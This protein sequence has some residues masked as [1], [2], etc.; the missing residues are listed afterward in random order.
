MTYRTKL[1]SKNNKLCPSLCYEDFKTT[2]IPLNIFLN[3]TRTVIFTVLM[4]R[5]LNID[6]FPFYISSDDLGY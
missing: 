1:N 5:G 4:I 2:Y 3:M 6:D